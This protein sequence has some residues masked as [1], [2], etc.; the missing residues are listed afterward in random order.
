[1][2]WVGCEHQPFAP[3]RQ[4]TIAALLCKRNGKVAFSLCANSAQKLK[5]I[6]VR[7]A[8]SGP[9][10]FRY[11]A[12][13]ASHSSRRLRFRFRSTRPQRLRGQTTALPIRPLAGLTR[14]PVHHSTLAECGLVAARP[15]A[16]QATLNRPHRSKQLKVCFSLLRRNR[17]RS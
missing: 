7:L 8:P 1:M 14:R 9:A 15:P 16:W 12:A 10:S 11:A 5:P 6:Y 13:A 17:C 2:S 3:G 4:L